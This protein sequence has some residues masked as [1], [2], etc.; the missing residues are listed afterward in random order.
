MHCKHC[1]AQA[2][3]EHFKKLHSNIQLPNERIAIINKIRNGTFLIE[4]AM[5]LAAIIISSKEINAFWEE[6]TT[7]EAPAPNKKRKELTPS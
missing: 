7:K 1:K 2:N 3:Y 5:D 6:H 4:S